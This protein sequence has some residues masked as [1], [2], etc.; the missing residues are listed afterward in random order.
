MNVVVGW[1]CDRYPHVHV[2]APKAQVWKLIID[3]SL[4]RGSPP[5]SCS[6]V[7]CSLQLIFSTTRSIRV[8]HPSIDFRWASSR[9][10]DIQPYRNTDSA[11]A[12]K[13]LILMRHAIQLYVYFLVI[14]LSVYLVPSDWLESQLLL[15][16]KMTMESVG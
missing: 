7:R 15:V 2:I 11:V 10:H 3:L 4:N 5:Y 13:K 16:N 14:P 1:S 6:L 12:W 9:V 8:Y